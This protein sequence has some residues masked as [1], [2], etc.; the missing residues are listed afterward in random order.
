MVLRFVK[1]CVVFLLLLA[2]MGAGAWAGGHTRVGVVIGPVWGPWYYPPTYY[3]PPYYPPYQPI[4]IQRAPQVYVEQY[5]PPQEIPP[6][7]ER[8]N[9]WYYCA[10]AKAYYPYVNECP[11]GWQKVLPQ[12]PAPQ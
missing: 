3:Y 9:Y 7:P 2:A 11:G 8:S 5:A 4:V 6:A 1:R 10:A 12:P